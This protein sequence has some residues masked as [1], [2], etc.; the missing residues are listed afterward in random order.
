MLSG[1]HL[2]GSSA[3]CFKYELDAHTTVVRRKTRNAP[4]TVITFAH[5]G[6]YNLQYC[7][8]QLLLLHYYII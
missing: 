1:V 2:Q 6:I 3:L 8:I 4:L 7:Y 5:P